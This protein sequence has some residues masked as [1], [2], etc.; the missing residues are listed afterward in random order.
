MRLR[1]W[2]IAYA[3]ERITSRLATFPSR[4]QTL[5]IAGQN[6]AFADQLERKTAGHCSRIETA[7]TSWI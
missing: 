3:V 2:E 4:T 6:A 5:N 7:I 1:G